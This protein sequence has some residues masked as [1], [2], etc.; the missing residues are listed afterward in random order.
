MIALENLKLISESITSAVHCAPSSLSVDVR[1]H[2]TGG[3]GTPDS[4]EIESEDDSTVKDIESN[5][6]ASL[7]KLESHHCIHLYSGRPDLRKILSEEVELTRGGKLSV[8][9]T[10]ASLGPTSIKG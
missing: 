5:A 8:N 3:F 4:G 9:G 2:V 6:S 10:S 7:T 1:F